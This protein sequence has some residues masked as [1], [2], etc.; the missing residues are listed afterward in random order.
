MLGGVLAEALRAVVHH[1]GD[2]GQV[3]LAARIGQLGDA[4]WPMGPAAGAAAGAPACRIRASMTLAMSRAPARSRDSMAE[5]T[6]SAGSSPA[7]SAA[8]RVRNSHRAWWDS[9]LA[10]A[11]RERGHDQVAVAVVAGVAGFGGP[12]RVQDGEVVGVGEVALPGLRG[13]QLGAVAV[14]DVGEYGDRFPRVRAARSG[15]QAAWP[16]RYPVA[17][18]P[19]VF[20]AVQLGGGP[21]A[22]LRV[23]GPGRGGEHEG[24]CWCRCRG[25]SPG[26]AT[27]GP[28]C[29]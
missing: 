2:L 9:S 24:Q 18:L 29:R 17:F 11:G 4:A 27:A 26:T 19:D 8:R 14:E 23:G 15:E 5:R 10:V 7:S 13:G 21:G 16:G 28:R 3:G 1:G 22:G 20:V 6:T 12:D 25:S